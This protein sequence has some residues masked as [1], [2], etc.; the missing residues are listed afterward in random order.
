MKADIYRILDANLN[1][2]RE[3]LRVCEDICRFIL[4]SS[5]LSSQFKSIRHS[6]VVASKNLPADSSQ[7]LKAR[8][9][10]RDVA[11]FFFPK[12]AKKK[13]GWQDIFRA[14]IQRAQEAIRVLEEFSNLIDRQSV[15]KFQRIRF[16]LY[17]LEK[18]VTA[19]I[20]DYYHR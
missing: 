6:I 1:R 13:R 7:L 9:S 20:A 18:R 8:N 11:K 10:D 12:N 4:N 2:S 5:S 14:N 19:L 16:R 3:G 15:T 17:N